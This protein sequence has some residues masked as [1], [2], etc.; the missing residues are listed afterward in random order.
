MT[1]FLA[2]ICGASFLR[3][4]ITAGPTISGS[5]RER[6]FALLALRMDPSA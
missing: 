4:E 3:L 6:S 1:G 2:T 5:K